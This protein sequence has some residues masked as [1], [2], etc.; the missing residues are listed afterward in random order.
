MPVGYQT[1]IGT[2]CWRSAATPLV[3]WRATLG[4]IVTINVSDRRTR[5]TSDCPRIPR[6]TCPASR[7][8]SC[9]KTLPALWTGSPRP[10]AS[11][12]ACGFLGLTE[13]STHAEM[14]L[15]DGVIMIGCPSREYQNPKRIGHVTQQLYL[16]VDDRGQAFRTRQGGGGDRFSKIPQDQ[17]YGD[18]LL[19]RRGSMK[20]ITGT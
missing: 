18:R 6:R 7:L 9:M 14:E 5:R 13:R 16:Y 19:R 1:S 10:S 2:R 17:F 3:G 11:G 12:S 8:T 4:P 20:G 15:A